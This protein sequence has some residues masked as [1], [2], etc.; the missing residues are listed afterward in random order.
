MLAPAAS[1]TGEVTYVAAWDTT[2]VTI[3]DDGAWTVTNDLGI[4]ITVTSGSLATYTVTLAAC[5][6]EHGWWLLG[7]FAPATALAGHAGDDDPA[8]LGIGGIEPITPGGPI[9]LETVTVHEPA[10]CQG[11]IAWGTTDGGATLTLEGF[12]DG[13]PFSIT[14][15]LSWG[16][17]P[18]LTRN[19]ASVHLEPG[20]DAVITLTRPL[21]GLFNGVDPVGDDAATAILRNLAAG[22]TFA[23][24]AGTAH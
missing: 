5:E 18:D 14:T 24:T 13:A 16:A 6:H 17:L 7:G 2:G 4:E 20:D 8:L 9:T 12:A 23:V 11:H 1:A 10:Y 19:D 22:T 15:G 3:G 21:A